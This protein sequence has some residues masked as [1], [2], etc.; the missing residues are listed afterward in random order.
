MYT[1]FHNKYNSC[2]FLFKFST[3]LELAF[4]NIII[5]VNVSQVE[6]EH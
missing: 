5:V 6:A 3:N 1:I 2:T 4:L